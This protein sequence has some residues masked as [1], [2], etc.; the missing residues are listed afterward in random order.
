MNELLE[1]WKQLGGGQGALLALT[2]AG[3]FSFFAH[4]KGWITIT[5]SGGNGNGKHKTDQCPD[6]ACHDTVVKTSQEIT[7]IKVDV[8]EL[9][10][11]ARD[12]AGG[13]KYISGRIDEAL[14]KT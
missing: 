4:K 2:G 9:F 5:R 3:A 1:I 8:K 6:P 12:N 13:I 14:K 10:N 11:I 7:D